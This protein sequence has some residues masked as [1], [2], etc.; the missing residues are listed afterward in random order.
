MVTRH[1]DGLRRV[2]VLCLTG[3]LVL[4]F[5]L[6]GCIEVDGVL[7][8]KPDGSATNT[9]EIRVAD[10]VAKELNRQALAARRKGQ[11]SSDALAFAD[12]C[13]SLA[14]P[15]DMGAKPDAPFP[16]VPTTARASKRGSKSVCTVTETISDPVNHFAAVTRALD[17]K[18]EDEQFDRAADGNSYR[19]ASSLQ[20][21]RV[22]EMAHGSGSGAVMDE[23]RRELPASAKLTFAVSSQRISDTDGTL[24]ATGR[25]AR[26]SFPL[27]VA[28]DRRPST[29]PLKSRAMIHFR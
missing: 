4:A 10:A 14:K 6:A 17:L 23:M 15:A 3:V 12:L 5:P 21:A 8:V 11:K 28:L 20:F 9:V 2:K 13:A 18:P 19:Y 1:L 29:P 27:R 24:D 7:S 26:W 22:L 25:T 16:K